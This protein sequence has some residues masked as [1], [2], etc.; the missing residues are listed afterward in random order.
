MAQAPIAARPV[1]HVLAS[2]VSYGD[3]SQFDGPTDGTCA[4][5]IPIGQRNPVG[6][7]VVDDLGNEYIYLLGV[8]SLAQGNWIQYANNNAGT[9]FKSSILPTAATFGFCGVAM[10]AAATGS[11]SSGPWFWA[12]IFGITPGPLGG[13]PTTY[14]AIAN[15]ATDASADGKIC[16]AGSATGRVATGQTTTK[17]I[18]GTCCVGAS[19]SNVGQVFL[20]YPYELGGATV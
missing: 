7:R 4:G 9:P 19:A 18:F 12:Q 10:S 8:A 2:V 15:I 3:L 5:A 1:G 17:N 16:S 11:A 20:Q 6:S 14:T 13:W